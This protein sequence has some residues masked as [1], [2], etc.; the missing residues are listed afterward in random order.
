VDLTTGTP[1]RFAPGR[2]GT[3][4]PELTI[5][6]KGTFGEPARWVTFNHGGHEQFILADRLQPVE[7]EA[8]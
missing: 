2:N 6:V 3:F 4:D 8:P 7:M 1:A 5:T